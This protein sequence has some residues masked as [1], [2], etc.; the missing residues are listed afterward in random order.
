MTQEFYPLF[1]RWVKGFGTPPLPLSFFLNYVRYLP[2][3]V[4]LFLVKHQGITIHAL[5]GFTTANRV[6]IIYMPSDKRYWDENPSDLACWEFIK[7]AAD[8]GYEYFDY[9]P[10]RYEGASHWKKKWGAE[11]FGYSYFFLPHNRE[12]PKDVMMY[13]AKAR[14]F[15]SSW[16][17]LMPS[18]TLTKAIG[19]WIRK[20]LGD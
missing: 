10:V 18:L 7:W 17:R 2:Q 6:H 16:A 11:F 3:Y 8:N 12:Y 1:L 14:F 15:A 20:Q 5:L 9:G 4:R 13:S 19:P